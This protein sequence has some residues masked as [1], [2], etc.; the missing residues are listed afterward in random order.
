[1]ATQRV[2][3]HEED[4]DPTPVSTDICESF[5]AQLGAAVTFTN[6]SGTQTITQVGDVWPFTVAPPMTVPNPATINI[7]SSG[8]M[9]GVEYPY[10]VS[11]A[12]PNGIQKGVTIIN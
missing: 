8:L 4:P 10:D 5:S 7:K 1:M 3:H 6:V 9:V 2:I 12:C 11:Q